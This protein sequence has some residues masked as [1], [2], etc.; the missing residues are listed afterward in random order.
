METGKISNRD[1]MLLLI[2]YFVGGRVLIGSIESIREDW[3][4]QFAVPVLC[5]PLIFLYISVAQRGSIGQTLEAAWGA[6]AGKVILFLLCVSAF[7]IAVSTLNA[8]AD[9]VAS[10][11]MISVN[12][13]VGSSAMGILCY[14]GCK[15]RDSTMAKIGWIVFPLVILLLGIVLLVGMRQMRL[16]NLLP[17]GES[18]A[19]TVL[20]AS[21]HIA[22]FQIS[23]LFIFIAMFGH[24]AASKNW[25]R[26]VIFG[27]LLV[28]LLVAVDK[29]KN[30]AVLG[31][32]LIDQFRFPTNAATSVLEL[33]ELFQRFE[34][35]TS[36]ALVLCQPVKALYGLKFVI[37]GFGRLFPKLK[38]AWAEIL[39]ALLIIVAS[40]PEEGWAVE[41]QPL[42][43]AG[44]AIM[45]VGIPVLTWVALKVKKIPPAGQEAGS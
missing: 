10:S 36:A 4:L 6:K 43:I 16:E 26:F 15:S 5:L 32:P 31:W 25:G 41:H 23:Q 30:V 22:L 8:Y 14:F 45:L 35:L 21:G 34:F 1:I 2:L 3:V 38:K 39:A 40:L 7:V 27:L 17:L 9:Y 11:A 12:R 44:T 20:E 29:I 19:K 28:S 33:G 24:R 13:W 37:E 18:G 42:H